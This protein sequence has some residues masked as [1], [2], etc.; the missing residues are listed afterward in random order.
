LPD[1]IRDKAVRVCS[2]FMTNAIAVSRADQHVKIRFELFFPVCALLSVWDSSP[3][4]ARLK[5]PD[6]HAPIDAEPDDLLKALDEI[7][8][9]ECGELPSLGGWGLNLV[10]VLADATGA[11]WPAPIPKAGKWMW[12][13]FEF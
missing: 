10:G 13:R 5:A 6:L 9:F 1:E 2:E 11:Y 7:P 8:D 12:A 3:R 4:P